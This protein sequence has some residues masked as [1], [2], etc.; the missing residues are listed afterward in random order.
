[1]ALL[2]VWLLWLST[3]VYGQPATNPTP[4]ALNPTS[5]SLA[6]AQ[7]MAVERN[8]DLLGAA[9]GIDAATAQKIVARE[10]PNPTLSLATSK[11]NVDNHPNST[12]A[13][14]GL[15]DRSYDTIFAINQLLE[16]G[17]KRASRKA[18]AQAG[19]EGTKAQF[20]DVKR[21]LDLG[22]TKAYA[23]AIQAE[24]NVRV[25]QQSAATL[26][27]EATIAET[28]LRAGEISA[29]DKEQIDIAAE[30]FELD[31]RAAAFTAA[32]A[33][34]ALEVLLGV[35]HPK[36]TLVLSDTLE[37]LSTAAMPAPVDEV[38]TWRP[39]VVAADAALRKAEAD[40]R[41][42]KANRIPDPTL[43]AQYEHEP[44]DNINSVGFGVSFP[45]PL[46]NRNRGNIMVA[47]AAREQ[48][49][50]AL[51]KTKAQAVADVATARLAYDDALR[52]WRSYRESIRPKSQQVRQ[53][54]AYAYQKG[55]AS[56][57]DLLI[58]E[59]NDNDIRL[60]ATQAAN[61]LVMATVTLKA[62]SLQMSP[63]QLRK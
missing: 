62:A 4:A 43:L 41:L 32:Q 19:F 37:N 53:T 25:L 21:L 29:S 36:G 63:S 34:I 51:E 49:R 57:L 58:A 15:W 11:I 38:P 17:G 28:R 59:R 16:I 44:P 48:A 39:D 24:E 54:I 12:A 33:R 55:G 6:Q 56:L 26:R 5:L 9:A 20:L 52:R 3:A 40:V 27:Q 18:V 22:V 7:Q 50:L 31:A 61:D 1:M 47:Q 14:N 60:A 35:P 2:P 13:G 8:W 23:A 45:L 30:R 10:F 42:Q 46:W